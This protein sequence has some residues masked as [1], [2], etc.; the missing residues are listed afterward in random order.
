MEHPHNLLKEI[1][2]DFVSQTYQGQIPDGYCFSLCYPLSVLFTLIDIKHELT[3][4]KSLKNNMEVSHFWITLDNNEIIL[5]PT[6][7]EFNPI[8]LPVYLGHIQENETT[9][10][11]IK[12]ENIGDQAFSQTYELWAE[13]LLQNKPLMQL[14]QALENKLISFNVA[15]AYVL[16]SYIHKLNLREKLL[17]SGYAVSYFKPISAVLKNNYPIDLSQFGLNYSLLKYGNEIQTIQ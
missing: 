8:E 2:E 5:D 4:G 15:A 1:S 3:F 10:K 11:F 14:P 7:K 9:S 16:M 13:P 17:N 12:I 6:I